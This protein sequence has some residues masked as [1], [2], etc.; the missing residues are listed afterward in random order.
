MP[1][2]YIVTS[3]LPYINGVKHLGNLIGSLLPADIYARYRRQQGDDVLAVCG[4]DE[5]GTP[6]EISAIA[7]G[8]P[9]EE[10]AA[11]YYQ[12]QKDIYKRF[13]LSFDYFGRTSSPQN[14]E[15]TR[16]IF[17]CLHRNGYIAE[18]TT[19]Q[20]WCEED[21]RYLPDRFVEGTCPR[22]GYES[23]RGDQC[24]NCNTLLDPTDLIDARSAISGSTNLETREVRHLFL[25]LPKLADRIRSWVDTRE[26]WPRTTRSIAYKWLDEGLQDRCITRDLKWGVPVPLEGWEDKVFYVWFDA[27]IGYI[28]ISMEWAAAIGEPDRWQDYW[29]SP[30]TKLV[31]FMA[32]DNVPFHTVTWPMTM[33][34]ADDGF[35]LADMIKGFQWL[36]YEGG[37]F[38]TSQGRGIF[39]DQAIELYPSDYWRYYLCLVAP[40][41]GDSDFSWGGFQDAVNK[42][43]ADT[44]G[45]FVLRGASFIRRYFDGVVPAQ[46]KPTD[47]DGELIGHLHERVQEAQEAIEAC[48]FQK[49]VRA[50]RKLWADCNR[51][52]D[53]KE[54]WHQ[55]K[56]D[57][58]AAGTTLGLAANLCRSIAI[59]AAPFIPDTA[60]S[61]FAQLGID[62]DVHSLPWSAALETS[63]LTGKRISDD[64]TPLVTKIEDEP[65][66]AL[67]QRFSGK[68]E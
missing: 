9:V 67:R 28:G 10:Y 66:A 40:E 39:T 47:A 38:S 8:L 54:P 58:D 14:H 26:S 25:E 59:L 4:T 24:D 44:L 12:I 52:F 20:L 68:G 15:M 50:Q 43:L 3:A 31:Q 57:M 22:C 45:N 30:D 42:D 6:A 29:K 55:R 64:A 13:R 1:P 17:L 46:I 53:A 5:H 56:A 63:A 21:Q 37:K 41:K 33:M 11:K 2:R 60:E 48:Q 19:K 16:R 23:A 32:K 18:R 51:Y 61:I 7:E 49:C 36:N 35:V 27:P 34:G 62:H 65:I